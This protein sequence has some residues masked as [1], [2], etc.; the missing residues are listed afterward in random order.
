LHIVPKAWPSLFLLQG[1]SLGSAAHL[2]SL[3]REAIGPFSVDAAW[4]F[5]Q[6]LDLAT[7]R[8]AER[9]FVE[10]QQLHQLQE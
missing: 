6:L 1:Q 9:R 2:R 4:N 7:Q 3:R 8:K 5:Q 10:Q